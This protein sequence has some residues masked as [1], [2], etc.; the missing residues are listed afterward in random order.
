MCYNFGRFSLGDG[1]MRLI[2]LLPADQYVVVNKTILTEIDKKNLINLYEPIIGFGAVS[3]Y[4]T[5]W[6]DLDTLE[7]MS[8][9]FTHHHLMSILKCSLEGIKQAREALEAVGLMKTYFKEGNINSYVYELYSPLAASEFF[10]NPILNIVL[11]N[12]VGEEEYHSLKKIYRKVNVDLKDYIEVTKTLNETFE[13]TS[14]PIVE[15]RSR[16]VLPLNIESDIDF[17]LIISSIPKGILNEK[18]I[19]KKIKELIIN[20][21][22]I[23][24]LDTLKMI[25]LIRASLNE[26]GI[27]EKETLRK[28]AR[29]YYQFNHGSLPTLVYRTQPEY[30]KTPIGDTSKKG[31]IIGVFENTSPYDFLKSKYHGSNP[32]SRDL[33]LLEML[34]IDL[35]LN[36]AVVNVLLD[37]V[38]KKNN[39]KL[40]ASYVETIAGQWKRAGVKTARE[41]MDLAQ[42]EHKKSQ[43]SGDKKFTKTLK[44][45]PVPVWFDKTLEKAEV[46]EEERKELEELLKI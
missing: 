27:I 35:E 37:Y 30:L 9:D 41:A 15:A 44:E 32:T 11:Y 13:S 3:L 21:S 31:R 25:E 20:L 12:N 45:V 29:K 40:S 2:T 17:D 8:R 33:K 39:N 46:S 26:K 14:V 42:K 18:A 43:K 22:F 10:S 38:L 34:M 23:Y 5:L 6:S 7:L 24:D 4:L 28:N 19:N 16:E 1:I 36:P